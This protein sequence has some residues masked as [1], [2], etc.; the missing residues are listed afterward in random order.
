MVI[1]FRVQP[2]H[3]SLLDLHF[4]RARPTMEDPVHGNP[5]VVGRETPP[6]FD[7]SSLA[8]FVGEMEESDVGHAVIMGQRGA[9]RWGN[10]SNEDIAQII[11]EYPGRFTG[12]G[13]I[14]PNGD[15]LADAKYAIEVLGLSGIALVPGWGDPPVVDDADQLL[16]LYEWCSLNGVPVS[17]TASHFI[18]PDMLHSHPVHLQRVAQQFPALTLIVAHGGW[19]WTTAACSLAMR[20]TNVYLMPDFYMYLPNMPGANDYVDAANGFLKHRMLYSSCYPSNSLKQALAHFRALPL[21]DDALE[22]LLFKNADR[23]LS[24]LA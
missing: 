22:H 20:C 16:G 17:V 9:E 18:G 7:A 13:G 6:S 8:L 5:F 24:G 15:V 11:A 10:A 1:D 19:P 12:F 23:L 2:P 14:D 3:R 21:S 4:F